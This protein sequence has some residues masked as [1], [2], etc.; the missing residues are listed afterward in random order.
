MYDDGD[1]CVVGAGRNWMK[2]NPISLLHYQKQSPILDVRK[3]S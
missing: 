1:D 3:T 2:S